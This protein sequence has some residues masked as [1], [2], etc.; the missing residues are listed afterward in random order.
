MPL[1]PTRGLGGL[2]R[3]GEAVEAFKDFG[4][5]AGQRFGSNKEIIDLIT[6]RIEAPTNYGGG[7]AGLDLIDLPDSAT[8]GSKGKGKSAALGALGRGLG[9][10]G[11]VLEMLGELKEER[12]RLEQTVPNIRKGLR[13][14]R[15]V[16]ST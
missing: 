16:Q 2:G 9:R 11:D 15:T 4:I 7:R 13:L 10:T 1:A 3:F 6:G 12:L 5:G 14:D 8:G